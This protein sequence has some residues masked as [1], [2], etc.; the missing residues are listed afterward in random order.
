M[1]DLHPP[2]ELLM[3]AVGREHG[4]HLEATLCRS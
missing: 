3:E 4:L 1:T 2:L